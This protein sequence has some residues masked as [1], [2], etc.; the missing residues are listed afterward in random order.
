MLNVTFAL[1]MV[2]SHQEAAKPLDEG[3]RV[4]LGDVIFRNPKSTRLLETELRMVESLLQA[5]PANAPDLPK[6]L[7]RAAEGNFEL[8]RSFTL[9][10]SRLADERAKAG[11]GD[12]AEKLLKSEKEAVAKAVKCRLRGIELCRRLADTPA[13]SAFPKLDQALFLLSH[14]LDPVSAE[15]WFERLRTEF[16]ASPFL[17]QAH[18]SRADLLYDARE[19]DKAHDAYGKCGD[20]PDSLLDEYARY[21]Q[22]WCL[23]GRQEYGKALPLFSQVAISIDAKSGARLRLECAQDALL[24][25]SLLPDRSAS[26][27]I[28]LARELAAPKDLK[29]VLERASE[30]Y[31]RRG[32]TAAQAAIDAE[33][34]KM[35]QAPEE[36]KK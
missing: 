31:K 26:D 1:V 5:S 25:Q 15:P 21:R 4:A 17:A 2:W 9:D 28:A 35:R 7:F 18:L 3:P 30:R 27:A 24:S 12:E 22:A 36:Q 13:F 10:A 23:L 16:P 8:M 11:S 32:L 33:I 14:H 6:V 29:P 19:F 20:F 34:E